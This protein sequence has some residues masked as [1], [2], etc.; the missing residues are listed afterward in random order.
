M[1]KS[2]DLQIMMNLP[3]FSNYMPPFSLCKLDWL[4]FAENSYGVFLEEWFTYDIII[5]LT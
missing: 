5:G 3:D 4:Q 2:Y 1:V